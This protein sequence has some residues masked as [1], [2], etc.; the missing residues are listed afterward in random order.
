M[1]SRT[2]SDSRS[3]SLNGSWVEVEQ[4]VRYYPPPSPVKHAPLNT[5]TLERLL[6]EAQRE[7]PKSISCANSPYSSRHSPRSPPPS[8]SE[9]L[10]VADI[11][12]AMAG[13]ES[14]GADWVW[15]WS[16][17]PEVVPPSDYACNMK[18]PLS[19][20]QKLSI[21]NTRV[22]HAIYLSLENLPMLIITHACTFVLG[23]ATMLIYLKKYWNLT[24]TISPVDG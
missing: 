21:R 3:D 20:W 16:S 17:R 23:A 9:D 2:S 14:G 8:P 6:R 13:Q 11:D 15:D 18:H 7:S 5:F 22:M 1:A 19:R 10:S 24:P 4:N 12:Q